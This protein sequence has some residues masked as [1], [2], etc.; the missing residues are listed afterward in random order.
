MICRQY[1]AHRR[2]YV[3]RI[4]DCRLTTKDGLLRLILECQYQHLYWKAQSITMMRL[5]AG[6]HIRLGS[7][8]SFFG[9]NFLACNDCVAQLECKRQYIVSRRSCESVV[10]VKIRD[11]KGPWTEGAPASHLTGQSKAPQ[12]CLTVIYTSSVKVLGDLLR[13]D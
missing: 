3:R 1:K 9:A 6:R 10:R 2:A 12:P 8:L 4:V 7:G 13:Y 11:Q 5:D